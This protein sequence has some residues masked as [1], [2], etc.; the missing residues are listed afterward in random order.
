M[1]TCL[2][3]F[4]IFK[5][6]HEGLL[7]FDINFVFLHCL[8]IAIYLNQ[9]QIHTS[10]CH[11][12]INMHVTI[13]ILS[14]DSFAN[15]LCRQQATTNIWQMRE[16]HESRVCVDQLHEFIHNLLVRCG[17]I[18]VGWHGVDHERALL[19]AYKPS[20]TIRAVVLFPND[21]LELELEWWWSHTVI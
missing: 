20:T 10:P 13:W 21:D 19:L 16:S 17:A 4:V 11:C 14:M 6:W 8:P 18:E 1:A 15:S 7:N 5:C 9:I 2:R 12:A 3:I